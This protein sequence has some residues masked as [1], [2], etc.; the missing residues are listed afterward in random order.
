M[1]PLSLSRRKNSVISLADRARDAGQWETAARLYRTALDRNPRNP[2]IWVQYGHALKESA[3]PAEAEAAYRRAI[4]YDPRIADSRLQLGH[5]LKLQGRKKEAAASYLSAFALDPSTPDPLLE[6]G[7]LGWS[8]AQL[9][10]LERSMARDD[11][12]PGIAPSANPTPSAPVTIHEADYLRPIFSVLIPVHSRTWQLREAL[13]SVLS[14]SFREF[15][16]IIVT[17]ASPPETIEIINHYIERDRR[18]RAFF[19]PDDSGNACRGRNRGIIEARGEFISL[20]DS[21]DLYFPD[22]LESVHEIFSTHDVDFVAGRASWIVDGS[23]KVGNLI[24]GNTNQRCNI[25]MAVLMRGNPFMTCTVHVK[26]D[27]LL[28]H[29]G[30][31][32]EQEYYEDLE[33][34][35]R[36][37]YGGCRFYYD[38]KLFAKYRLHAGNTELKYIAAR[39]QWMVQMRHNY[40]RPFLEWGI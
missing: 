5:L 8:E 39:Q 37:A 28:K 10:E 38:D 36:L 19:Y 15:E 7:R 34:W 24:T 32:P 17:N 4:A 11:P 29:G 35:L 30:F 14:Q 40:T 3:K 16:V 18:V 33:L 21:D 20:L 1:R 2:P 23:R 13:D 22:T 12:Q 31:R 9:Y 25:N 6:L 27:L 26:R